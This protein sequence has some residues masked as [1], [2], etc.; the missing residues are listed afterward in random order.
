MDAL[1]G[2]NLSHS[3]QMT[4]MMP[5]VFASRCPGDSGVVNRVVGSDLLWYEGHQCVIR[6]LQKR[7]TITT[8]WRMNRRKICTIQSHAHTIQTLQTVSSFF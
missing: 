6:H 3:F 4:S 8:Y 2:K 1:S 5:T 7:K